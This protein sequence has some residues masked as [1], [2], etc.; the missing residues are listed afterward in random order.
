MSALIEFAPLLGRGLLITCGLTL[1]A[2]ML[3][4][5]LGLSGALAKLSTL[6]WLRALASGYTTVVRGIPELLWVLLIYLGTLP[7][8]RAMGELFGH[9]DWALPPFWA[10][11]LALGLCYGAYATEVFRG[12]LLAIGRGQGEA[13]LAL[14]LSAAQVL[15]RITL[16]PMFRI[17][18]PGLG[19]LLMILIKDSALVSV[20]GLAELMGSTEVA[21]AAVQRP[22]TFYGV[23]AGI[24]LLVTLAIN[25]GLRRLEAPAWRKR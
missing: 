20:I 10:G 7:L 24:N 22:F 16:P 6:A 23:A 19:N 9:D 25:Q 8:V 1:A 14:G 4:L 15:W 12:A 2:L 17:A 21:V 5:L 11:A 18:L 13:G 3:G